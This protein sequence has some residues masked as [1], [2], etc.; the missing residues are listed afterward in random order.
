MKKI[1]VAIFAIGFFCSCGKDKDTGINYL[2]TLDNVK[3][4][5]K[6]T[7]R[8]SLPK[9]LIVPDVRIEYTY[10]GDTSY[11]ALYHHPYAK[12]EVI[13]REEG[14]YKIIENS[15][16]WYSVYHRYEINGKPNTLSLDLEVLT[17]QTLR[18]RGYSQ[19]YV[20]LSSLN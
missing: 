13:L 18:Y 10:D 9:D 19:G 17:D 14:S 11:Y 16:G 2:S 3:I 6:G 1:L 20:R 8:T 15:T 7:W 4:G 5:V 12:D